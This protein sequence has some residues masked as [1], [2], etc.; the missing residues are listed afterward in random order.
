MKVVGENIANLKPYQP[1]KPIEELERELGI[2]G[3]IKLASNEN[4]L[5]PS[6]R[7]IEAIRAAAPRTHYYPD[8]GTYRLREALAQKH[9][10]EM[11]EIVVGNGSNEVLTLLARTFCGPGET[12]VISDYSFIAYRLI[13]T[14]ANIGFTSVPT[15]AR[16][17]QDLPALADACDEKTKLLF[18]ANP[19][20]PTGVHAGRDQLRDFLRDVPE[21]VVVAIDEAYVEYALADDYASALELRDVR[22]RLVVCRTFSKCYGLAGLRVGY[23]IAPPELIDYMNRVREPF[24][25]NL[26]GQAA[27]LA[28][29]DDP[30]HL[31]RSVESNEESRGLMESGLR[32]IGLDWIPSQTNFLLVGTPGPGSDVYESMLRDG[33]IVRPVAGYGLTDWVRITLGTPDETRRCLESLERAVR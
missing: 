11:N 26:V 28:A 31:R 16:L 2:S 1:G 12:A 21:H 7:A 33:V 20:N 10:V 17:M 27:A 19:N 22:E 18:L 25:S 9:D 15:G 24:N 32:E 5:G 14:A 3:S 23:G 8:A 6:P 13:L 30:E 29:L 4:P